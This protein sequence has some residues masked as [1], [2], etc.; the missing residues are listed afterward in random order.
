MIAGLIPPDAGEILFDGKPL[1]QTRFGYVFQNHREALFPG[2]ARSRTSNIR[3]AGWA[4]PRPS[5]V[6]GWNGW[7]PISASRST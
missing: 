6:R 5:A 7:S 4:C 1:S 2:C 3:S